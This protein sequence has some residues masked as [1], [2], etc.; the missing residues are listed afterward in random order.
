MPPDISSGARLEKV[1]QELEAEA[2]NERISHEIKS[3]KNVGPD[4]DKKRREEDSEGYTTRGNYIYIED[5]TAF[6]LIWSRLIFFGTLQILY[7]VAFY[8]L[9]LGSSPTVIW[10]WIFSWV[11]FTYSGLGVT[12]GSH[13]LWSHKS[14]QARWPLRVFLMVGQCLAG[15][16]TLYTW[17]RDHRYCHHCFP[18]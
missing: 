11:L 18:L 8:E 13:R 7:F 15:Q 9:F 4:G 5:G 16:N 3:L 12:A 17:C 10:T 2:R 6:S 1:L 14:Y